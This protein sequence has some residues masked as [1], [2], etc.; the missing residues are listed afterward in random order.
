MKVPDCELLNSEV[1]VI[2]KLALRTATEILENPK[3]VQPFQQ[4]PVAEINALQSA[5]QKLSGDCKTVDCTCIVW[6]S[7]TETTADT[8]KAEQPRKPWTFPPPPAKLFFFWLGGD[9]RAFRSSSVV[10]EF[11]A[12]DN[13]HPHVR[14]QYAT[15]GADVNQ[16]IPRS[17]GIW[18]GSPS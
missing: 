9:A 5:W 12:T 11:D 14:L 4:D 10:K 17:F 8:D 15:I 7:K 18:E 1:Y 3:L 16:E 2:D 13:S 6:V